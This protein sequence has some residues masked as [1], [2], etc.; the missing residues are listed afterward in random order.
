MDSVAGMLEI[1]RTDDTHEI[2]INYCAANPDVGEPNKVVISPR[3]ARYFASLLLEH[4]ADAEAEA[5]GISQTSDTRNRLANSGRLVYDSLFQVIDALTEIPL[6]LSVND[7]RIMT[8]FPLTR[9]TRALKTLVACNC[10]S[11]DGKGCY[12]L[13]ED[14]ALFSKT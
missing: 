3:H 13:N 6:G 12:R 14:F 11:C 1:W 8:G 10:I 2:V 4:A 9:M 5:S 7:L